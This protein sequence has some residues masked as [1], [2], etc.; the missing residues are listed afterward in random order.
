MAEAGIGSLQGKT[1]LITGAAGGL[2]EVIAHTLSRY[3][4]KLVLVDIPKCDS[5]LKEIAASL[6]SA[7]YC[8]ADLLN[9]AA[10]SSLPSK[11]GDIDGL[12]NC[13]GVAFISPLMEQT[14]KDWDLTMNINA[15]AIFLVSQ[16]FAG[17]WIKQGKKGTIVN[18]SSQASVAPLPGHLTYCASKAAVDMITRMMCMELGQHGIRVNSV[19]PTVV[20]TSMGKANWSDPAKAGPMLSAIPLNRFAEPEELSQTV[21]WLL[22][23]AAGMVNGHQLLLDGGF[24]ATRANL[25]P[26]PKM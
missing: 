15:R 4:C 14:V 18:I 20:L 1:V 8:T 22:C 2:G 10:C 25:M 13:A 26:K 16:A 17:V 21:A 5:K 9:P 3:G 24:Y 7:T 11:A 6:K 23:D 12:V 19:N